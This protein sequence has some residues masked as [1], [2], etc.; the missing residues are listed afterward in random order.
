MAGALQKK[1]Y[2]QAVPLTVEHF[3]VPKGLSRAIAMELHTGS[4][5]LQLYSF[6]TWVSCSPLLMGKAFRTLLC[7]RLSSGWLH[8]ISELVR[9]LSDSIRA[10]LVVLL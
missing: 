10:H 8:V 4:T 2:Y 9:G 7:F 5:R 1:L 3:T 6:I